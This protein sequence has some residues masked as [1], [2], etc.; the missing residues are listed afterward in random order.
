M[1]SQFDP[2]QLSLSED[3]MKHMLNY[4][5]RYLSCFR[6][7]GFDLNGVEVVLVEEDSPKD[8][9][10]LN[11]LIIEAGDTSSMDVIN[12][13]DEEDEDEESWKDEGEDST[14]F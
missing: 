9:R 4:V 8:A 10:A 14:G 5:K 2:K 1:D 3:D 7:Y 11:D 13:D 12:I 6:I